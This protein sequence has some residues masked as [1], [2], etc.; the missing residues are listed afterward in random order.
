M[1][2]F[3][4]SPDLEGKIVIVSEFERIKYKFIRLSLPCWTVVPLSSSPSV[5]PVYPL[6]TH[7]NENQQNVSTNRSKQ[8]LIKAAIPY[9][10]VLSPR[11]TSRT[12]PTMKDKIIIAHIGRDR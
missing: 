4:K 1:T 12:I 8:V 2:V 9:P 7:N 11:V 6:A 10:R 5:S 3:A